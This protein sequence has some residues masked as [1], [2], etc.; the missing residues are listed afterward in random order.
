MVLGDVVYNNDF[1]TNLHYKV[2]HGVWDD[3]GTMLWNTLENGYDKPSDALLN[4][5]IVYMT[6]DI[7]EGSLVIEVE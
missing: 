5:K 3:D 2:F 4:R 6:I 1:D 7:D